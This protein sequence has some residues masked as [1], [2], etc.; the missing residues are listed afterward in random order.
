M[1]THY[2]IQQQPEQE[3]RCVTRDSYQDMQPIAYVLKDDFIS[4]KKAEYVRQ[5]DVRYQV[6]KNNVIQPQPKQEKPLCNLQPIRY[7]TKKASN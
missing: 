2:V 3:V 7:V 6:R 1:R 4:D 5:R